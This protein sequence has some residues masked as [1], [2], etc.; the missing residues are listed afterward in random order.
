MSDLKTPEVALAGGAP[1]RATSPDEDFS[2][3]MGIAL[4]ASLGINFLLF[5]GTGLLADSMERAKE[6][7]PVQIT[8]RPAVIV[9]ATPTPAPAVVPT[10]VAATPVPATPRAERPTPAPATPRPTPVAATPIPVRPTPA[11]ATPRPTPMAATPPPAP[12]LT[13]KNIARTTA[14]VATAAVATAAV[15]RTANAVQ[16]PST[17]QAVDIK[18]TALAAQPTNVTQTTIT[19]AMKRELE[20]LRPTSAQPLLGTQRGTTFVAK[21]PT[22]SSGTVNISATTARTNSV[23]GRTVSAAPASVSGT[24]NPVTVQ[25][26]ARSTLSGDTRQITTVRGVASSAKGRTSVVTMSAKSSEVSPSSF[27]VQ[28]GGSIKAGVATARQGGSGTTAI[29]AVAGAP[30][31][32]STSGEYAVYAPQVE[33]R[34]VIG[35]RGTARSPVGSRVTELQQ[36]GDIGQV[37]AGTAVLAAAPSGRAAS[38]TQARAA[39]SAANVAGVELAARP[40]DGVGGGAVRGETRDTEAVAV[41]GS[42]GTGQ[43]SK[44]VR[45]GGGVGNGPRGSEAG[46][47]AGVANGVAG[48]TP[49]RGGTVGARAAQAGSVNA[50]AGGGAKAVDNVSEKTT[51]VAAKTVERKVVN[52]DPDLGQSELDLPGKVNNQVAA[53][54]VSRG[55]FDL[56]DNLRSMPFKGSVT[57]RVTVDANGS[58]TE[59]VTDGSGNASMDQAALAYMKRWRWEAAKQDGKTVRSVTTVKLPI[60]IK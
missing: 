30:T 56:T 24:L 3:R 39:A 12:A 55:S 54:P 23:S 14:A 58:H 52:L 25:P 31:A 48:G 8:M 28:T 44:S 4:A 36:K 49:S 15:T 45:V 40:G 7:A 11:P 27:V 2:R 34:G 51:A 16:R 50:A 46:S 17:T 5:A 22:S 1:S 6:A 26:E 47:V 41:R 33:T 10:P 35:I 60:E 9:P 20:T 53:K 21:S 38:T 37:V 13:Q 19:P 29:A 57:I 32:I 59:E 43:A 18:N 42:G